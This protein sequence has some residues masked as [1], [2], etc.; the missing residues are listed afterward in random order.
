MSGCPRTGCFPLQHLGT[1]LMSDVPSDPVPLWSVTVSS[2]S[3]APTG[4][5]QAQLS[6]GKTLGDNELNAFYLH[7][8]LP[9]WGKGSMAAAQISLC[10]VC[11]Q[12]SRPL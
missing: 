5:S 1:K 3:L 12:A 9:S 11:S 4:R 7:L 8:L 2:L 10:P 6:D